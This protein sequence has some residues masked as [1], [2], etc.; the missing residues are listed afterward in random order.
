[1]PP[2]I[3]VQNLRKTFYPR[4]GL[5]RWLSASPISH[6]LNVLDGLSF[7][8]QRGEIFG[9]LGPNGSGKST[10][11]RILATL[12]HPTGGE[13]RVLGHDTVRDE[14]RVRE[15]VGL[16][17]G[18]ERSFY[19]RLTGRQNLRFFAALYGLRG[20]A[21]ARRIEEV[22]ALLFMGDYL[23]QRYDAYSTGMRQKLSLA[24][25][26]LGGAAVLLLDEPTRALDPAASGNLLGA[27]QTL[28]RDAG[29]TIMMVTHRVSEARAVCDRIGILS[30]GRLKL[31]SDLD[32]IG[33]GAGSAK[34]YTFHAAPDARRAEKSLDGFGFASAVQ[35]DTTTLSLTIEEPA[36]NLAKVLDLL[37]RKG[38]RILHVE[39]ADAPAQRR[40]G[41]DRRQE[42][43]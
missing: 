2:A 15:N 20:R 22:A 14:A 10:L 35:C 43:G 5:A 32:A 38:L 42:V 19:W 33:D 3:D 17:L 39:S 7:Q 34:R 31:V 30:K 25:G 40:V 26:L 23:D 41:T 29:A 36:Q 21:G 28:S 16:V 9:L 6:D 37:G 27:I 4:R 11:L 18:D 12:M 8:V 24:R 1:M 13:A